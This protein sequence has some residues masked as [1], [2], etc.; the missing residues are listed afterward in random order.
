MLCLSRDLS[1][2]YARHALEFFHNNK[3]P[4]QDMKAADELVGNKSF[5]NSAYC[6]ADEGNTWLVY[7]PDC[8]E[9]ELMLPGKSRLTI[10]W[11]NPRTG[12]LG[13]TTPLKSPELRAPDNNDWLAIVRR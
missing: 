3:I 11:F 4:F 2:D 10:A 9:C 6:L 12:D 8:G 5:G 13:E 7:L 1:W